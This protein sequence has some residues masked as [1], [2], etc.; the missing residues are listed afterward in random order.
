MRYMVAR[1][2]TTPPDMLE[3]TKAEYGHILAAGRQLQRLTDAEDKLELLIENFIE[4]EDALLRIALE[5]RASEPIGLVRQYDWAHGRRLLRT[6]NRRLANL[7]TAG[8]LCE[9]QLGHDIRALGW[10]TS[11]EREEYERGKKR[12]LKGCFGFS[13]VRKLRHHI[14]HRQLPITGLS[15]SGDRN[16]PGEALR[17]RA[18]ARLEVHRLREDPRFPPAARKKLEEWG[19]DI[20]VAPLVYEYLEGIGQ[21]YETYRIVT[22]KLAAKAEGRLKTTLKRA[23]EKFGAVDPTV[24]LLREYAGGAFEQDLQIFKDQLEYRTKLKNKNM[25]IRRLSN[26]FVSSQVTLDDSLR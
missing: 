17:Y 20:A 14:Q 11:A 26:S 1:L 10:L 16:Q 5:E 9:D 21:L 23:K 13:M 25:K 7:V 4:F 3:V 24:T 8:K 15:V 6:L 12:I 19:S 18:I 22:K 2:T